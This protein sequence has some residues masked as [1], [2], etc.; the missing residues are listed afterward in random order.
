MPD[1]AVQDAIDRGNRTAEL[2]VKYRDQLFE[3]MAALLLITGPEGLRACAAGV[4]EAVIQAS[5]KHPYPI[6]EDALLDHC[7]VNVASS[8]IVDFPDEGADG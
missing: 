7:L 6:G 3:P 1:R 4:T 5:R 8:T 2:L